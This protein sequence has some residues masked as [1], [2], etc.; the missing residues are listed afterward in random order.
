MQIQA[1]LRR[2]TQPGP[3]ILKSV[4]ERLEPASGPAPREPKTAS[5]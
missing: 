1:V 2:E 5:P 3:S 4:E